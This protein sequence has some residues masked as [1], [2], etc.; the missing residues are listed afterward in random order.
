MNYQNKYYKYK[1]KYLFLTGGEEEPY[2]ENLGEQF[3]PTLNSETTPY[4]YLIGGGNE[5]QKNHRY[6][7]LQDDLEGEHQFINDFLEG[8]QFFTTRNLEEAIEL[9]KQYPDKDDFGVSLSICFI[10]PNNL[11]V[12][13]AYCLLAYHYSQCSRYH[14]RTRPG[15]PLSFQNDIGEVEDR[16]RPEGQPL[17]EDLTLSVPEFRVV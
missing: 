2:L 1:T 12:E 16:V 6:T 8:P 5:I 4:L 14:S 10:H 13:R 9:F 17:R 15:L 11:I 3:Y 7:N